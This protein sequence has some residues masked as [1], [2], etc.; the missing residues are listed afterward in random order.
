M[1][2]QL[3][4]EVLITCNCGARIFLHTDWLRLDRLDF[5][6][7]SNCGKPFTLLKTKHGLTVKP[8][9]VG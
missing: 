6:R 2:L 4:N 7:C 5:G 8:G 1:T 3:D 9:G